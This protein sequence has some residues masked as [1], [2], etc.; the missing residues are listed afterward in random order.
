M[1]NP[2]TTSLPDL[3]NIEQLIDGEGQITI[4]AIH[5]LRCVAIANDGHNSLAMLVRRDGETLA[6]LLIR[7]DAA[8]A[9]ACNEETFT[10]EVNV[11][12]PR[13][14]PPRRR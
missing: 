7:L 14:T 11:P 3:P 4:G 5:P 13:Q 2:S 1:P 10:D 9:K 12:P 8:I 6:Q